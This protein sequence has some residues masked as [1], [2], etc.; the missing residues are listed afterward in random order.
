MKVQEN[1]AIENGTIY[2]YSGRKI[3]KNVSG[4]LK[5]HLPVI[6]K[7]GVRDGL[8]NTYHERFYYCP[9]CRTCLAIHNGVIWEDNPGHYG[10][11]FCHECGYKLNWEIIDEKELFKVFSEEY[12]GDIVVYEEDT[13]N[14][15][16]GGNIAKEMGLD[17]I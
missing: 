13:K 3:A 12:P 8:S 17:E 2:D 6:L 15:L 9:K 4:K 10:E 16:F 1:I 5:V 14:V 11:K 7:R